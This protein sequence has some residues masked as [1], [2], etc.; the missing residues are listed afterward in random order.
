MSEAPGSF[1]A[2]LTKSEEAFYGIDFRVRTAPAREDFSDANIARLARIAMIAMMLVSWLENE[3]R[4]NWKAGPD[5]RL[6]KVCASEGHY[7]CLSFKSLFFRSV[8]MTT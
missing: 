5:G 4:S 1:S 3:K 7:P 6:Q 2:S 8:N